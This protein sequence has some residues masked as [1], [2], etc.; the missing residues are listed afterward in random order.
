MGA[1]LAVSLTATVL[2]QLG[3]GSAAVARARGLRRKLQGGGY[4]S[5]DDAPPP[6]APA[7]RQLLALLTRERAARGLRPYDLRVFVS[8]LAV[9]RYA[10]RLGRARPVGAQI[11]SSMPQ[12]VAGLAP[13]M[14]WE[15][16]GDRFADRDAH[17][18]SVRRW[19]DLLQ[20]LGLIRWQAGINDTGEEARTEITLLASSRR[21]RRRAARRGQAP[22]GVA[23]ALRPALGNRRAALPAGHRPAVAAPDA[24]AAKEDRGRPRPGDRQRAAVIYRFGT[25]LRGSS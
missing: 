23:A 13:I 9:S 7:P 10:H 2:P 14:G 4:A 20:A 22:R 16:S 11:A 21:R 1:V 24:R 12:L 5:L 8:L 15:R 6:A 3:A 18:A 17:H 25:P 19:L